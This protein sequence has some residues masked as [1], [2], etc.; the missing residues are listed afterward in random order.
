MITSN[1]SRAPVPEKR[2]SIKIFGLT[3]ISAVKQQVTG[4]TQDKVGIILP[5]Y[6]ERENI[7]QLVPALEKMFN[8]NHIDGY[9][10][11]VDDN[12]AD[13]TGQEALRFAHQ[14]NNIIVIRRPGKFGLGSA[15]RV[16]FE[17]AIASGMDI[18][19][20]MDSDLS[21]RPSYIPVF[22]SAM[23]KTGADF[24]I[25]SRYCKGGGTSGWPLKRKMISGGAN[26]LSRILLG[27]THVHDTTSGFRAFKANT[28]EQIEYNTVLSNGYSF[29]G[30]LLSRFKAA[31]L[32]IQEVPII[33]YERIHGSSRLG[34]HEIKGF[35][36]FT[37]KTVF[38]RILKLLPGNSIPIFRGSISKK[39]EPA[40]R[41]IMESWQVLNINGT[42]YPFDAYHFT[43][44]PYNR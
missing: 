42:V 44:N 2:R 9:L 13:G 36:F 23:K 31:R 38:D 29:Q 4:Q 16:G 10:F 15:Y 24:V 7:I 33:F 37:I 41:K 11:F 43:Q 20:M 39:E 17:Y 40:P 3:N 27:L 14:Y 8:T 34:S 18:I 30:E 35:L 26:L 21:H 12:S 1:K 19:F 6:N 22:L 5:T 28:L 32:N 25:G